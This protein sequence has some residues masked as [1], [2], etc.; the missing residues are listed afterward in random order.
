M[1]Y[2]LYQRNVLQDDEGGEAAK[3]RGVYS[4][5]PSGC[6]LGGPPSTLMPANATVPF[7]VRCRTVSFSSP[8]RLGVPAAGQHEID[9]TS[10]LV[11]GTEQARGSTATPRSSIISSRSR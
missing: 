8:V 10:L 9:Q 6:G 5:L 11:D 2:L 1:V 3:L 7:D 4:R